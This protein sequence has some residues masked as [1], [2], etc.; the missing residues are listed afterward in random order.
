MIEFLKKWN[1]RLN[2]LMGCDSEFCRVSAPTG[3]DA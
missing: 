1:H 3:G 2:V